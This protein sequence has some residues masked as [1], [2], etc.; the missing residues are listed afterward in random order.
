MR[1]NRLALRRTEVLGDPL[2]LGML[3]APIGIGLKLRLLIAAI[4]ACEPRRARAVA[5]PVDP[6]AGDTGIG[7]TS[8]AAAQRNQLAG[9]GQAIRRRA[10]DRTAT[11]QRDRCQPDDRKTVEPM[12]HA[13]EP[14]PPAVVPD[15]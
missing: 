9:G 5:P 2:H 13:P 7:R 1:R 6:V 3:A 14:P 11:G 12:H 8:V 15:V 4:K 10:V